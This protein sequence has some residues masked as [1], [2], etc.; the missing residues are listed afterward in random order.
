[1]EPSPPR[2]DRRW[3]IAIALGL[4]LVI[5]VNL[6]FIYIAVHGK[7]EIAPSYHSERR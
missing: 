1:L 7:D 5:L 2:T 3:P 6:A 4:L